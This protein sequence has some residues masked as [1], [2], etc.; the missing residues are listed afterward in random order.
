MTTWDE[1][2]APRQQTEPRL[3]LSETC[4]RFIGPSRKVFECGIYRT[5][6]G[7]EVRAGYGFDDLVRSDRAVEIGSARVIAAEWRDAV[8]AKG[9]LLKS[10]PRSV[11]AVT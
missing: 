9:G 2:F 10:R 6:V 8:L 11:T 4:W 3:E 7:L 1:R 5:D